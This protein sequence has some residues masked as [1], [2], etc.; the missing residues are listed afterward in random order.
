IRDFHVTGVQTC[1]RPILAVMEAVARISHSKLGQVDTAVT[2][3]AVL[4][5]LMRCGY[6]EAADIT[7]RYGDP[8]ALSP[9]LDTNIVCDGGI[10][11]EAEFNSDSEFRKTAS[12]MKLVIGGYAGAG[13][14]TIG[15]YD[16]HTGE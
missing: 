13:C 1:A 16:Y 10:F 4:K 9:V 14:V 8:S 3:D 5:E 11:T 12:I 15:G 6:I 7:D 2:Q